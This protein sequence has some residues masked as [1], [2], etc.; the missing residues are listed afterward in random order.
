MRFPFVILALLVL[1]PLAELTVIIK[2]GGSIGILPTIGLL[3]GIGILGSVLIRRQGLSVLRK[4]SEA[5][6]AGKVP[7]DS[8]FD[9]IGLMMAGVLMMTPGFLTDILGLA[10]LVPPFRRRA[11]QWLLSRVTVAGMGHV[12]TTRT[13]WRQQPGKTENSPGTVID[14]E[15][16]RVD[17]A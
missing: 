15:F 7:L 11:A 10:L 6:A 9:G 4:T 3:I 1:V 17:D 13:K 2:V 5:M 8:A 12:R 14:G 16:T